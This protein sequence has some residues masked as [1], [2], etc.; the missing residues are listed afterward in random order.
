MFPQ[1]YGQWK[2]SGE[3]YAIVWANHASQNPVNHDTYLIQKNLIEHK[4]KYIQILSNT[5]IGSK[6]K[7]IYSSYS[8][9]NNGGFGFPDGKSDCSKCINEQCRN[10]CTKSVPFQ[11]AYNPLSIGY[12]PGDSSNWKEGTYSRVHRD[13]EIVNAMRQWME[14]NTFANENELYQYEKL[15]VVCPEKC[16]I[17]NEESKNMDMCIYCN[18]ER[19]YYPVFNGYERYYKCLH[20]SYHEKY[21]FDE[22]NKYF[23]PCYKTCKTCEKEGNELAN[24]CLTCIENYVLRKDED[25]IDKKNCV[26]LY[27]INITIPHYIFLN[28][29]ET[30]IKENTDI[31]KEKERDKEDIDLSTNIYTKFPIL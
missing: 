22:E 19:E 23:L 30:S 31:I 11:K 5:S 21:Y 17:C 10:T 8:I 24:N 25:Y 2:I 18:I 29:I 28:P 1:C 27:K 26:P 20:I 3:R 16:S 9:M 15:K 4:Q 13:F 12:D 14:L 7:L 6:I